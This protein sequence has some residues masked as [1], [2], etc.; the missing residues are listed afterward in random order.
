MEK[1]SPDWTEATHLLTAQRQRWITKYRSDRLFRFFC[2]TSI[3]FLIVVLGAI[4]LFVSKTGLLVF[5]DISP[6]EFFFSSRWDPEHHRYGAA[7]FI[8]GTLYLTFVTLL[9]ATP[10]SILTA[11]F[12]AEMA[13]PRLQ[14]WLRTLLD[15]LVGIPSIVY[16]YLGATLLVPWIRKL[17]GAPVGDGILAAAIVLSMMILPTITRITDD[18][19]CAVP[20]EWREANYALGGTKIEMIAKVLLPAAKSGIAAAVILG[21][22]R[23]IGETMAV[24]MVIGNVAQWGF[25]LVTP[26]S[27]LTSHIVMQILNVDFQSTTNHALYMM[28]LLLLFI[29]ISFIMMIRRLRLKGGPSS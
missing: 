29:S 2:L 17:T 24:V 18:A 23:A 28:A 22:A 16:G 19:L 6:S 26:S 4:V 5:R 27:V 25:D 11:I 1:L 13:P 15:L 9:M 8:T 20:N 12:I 10:I 14:Q 7:V 21:M 3:V